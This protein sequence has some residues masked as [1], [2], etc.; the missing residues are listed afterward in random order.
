MMPAIMVQVCV[1]VIVQHII[2]VVGISSHRNVS[3][4]KQAIVRLIVGALLDEQ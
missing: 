1:I 3:D 2:M 4:I